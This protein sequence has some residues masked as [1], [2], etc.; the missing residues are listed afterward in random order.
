M[1]RTI[2]KGVLILSAFAMYF[3]VVACGPRFKEP[4]P[5]PTFIEFPV[6][7]GYQKGHNPKIVGN[8][9]WKVGIEIEVGTYTTTAPD[10]TPGCYW[11]RLKSFDGEPKSLIRNGTVTQGS[12]GRFTI[13]KNDVGV[14]LSGDCTWEKEE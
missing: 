11:A 10:T 7:T 3:V 6:A 9:D 13:N 1:I 4:E 2:A 14:K 12:K 8:G 5:T